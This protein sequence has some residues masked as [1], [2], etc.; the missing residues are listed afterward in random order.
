MKLRNTKTAVFIILAVVFV[1][2]VCVAVLKSL[3]G[4]SPYEYLQKH[5]SDASVSPSELLYSQT[6][7]E[8]ISIV[9][10]R[11]QQGKYRC[12]VQRTAPLVTTYSV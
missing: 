2:V 9:F 12:A 3:S 1:S 7:A 5:V 6:D 11:S 4:Q 8:G 10:Y